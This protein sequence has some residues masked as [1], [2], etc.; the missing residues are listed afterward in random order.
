MSSDLKIG[1]LSTIYS[2]WLHNN[3]AIG[4][5]VI[6]G[7]SALLLIFRPQRKFFLFFLGF[8]FLILEFEYQKHFA[9]ALEQQT[10]NSI[11]I[12]GKH[13][14]TRSI[15]EDFFQKLVPFS[16]WLVGWGLVAL[17]IIASNEKKISK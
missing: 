16:L 2:T 5:L 11:I 14:Q 8:L 3:L 13:L 15:L 17:G 6:I 9:E 7:V 10:V 4:F 12:S 1:I